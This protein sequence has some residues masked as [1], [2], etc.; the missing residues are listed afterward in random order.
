MKRLTK[1]SADLNPFILVSIRYQRLLTTKFLPTIR[2]T[3]TQLQFP[4]TRGDMGRKCCHYDLYHLRSKVLLGRTNK[5]AAAKGHISVAS[6]V[7]N[8]APPRWLEEPG[9]TAPNG[10]NPMTSFDVGSHNLRVR[11]SGHVEFAI[12]TFSWR[13]EPERL[14][15]DVSC[16][17]GTGTWPAFLKACLG[18][19]GKKVAKDLFP[20]GLD[21]LT[22]CHLHR[23]E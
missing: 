21:P 12:D 11:F 19:V 8:P 23:T 18:W 2:T 14:V 4:V 7:A 1:P 5:R 10:R 13:I 17:Y 9:F 6:L 15:D 20:F 3:D 22:K 16:G